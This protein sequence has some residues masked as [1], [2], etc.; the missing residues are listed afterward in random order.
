MFASLVCAAHRNRPELPAVV[1]AADLSAVGGVVVGVRRQE[2]EPVAV[3]A[4]HGPADA[5]VVRRCG[6]ELS[7]LTLWWGL[8]VWGVS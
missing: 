8:A 5:R 3:A 1:D 4:G 7:P 2:P 6:P